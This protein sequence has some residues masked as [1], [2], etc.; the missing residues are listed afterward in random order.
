ME[1][2][3][4]VEP[5]SIDDLKKWV[6]EIAD[7][8]NRYQLKEI[9]KISGHS[10]PVSEDEDSLK[11]DEG[12]S[13]RK[14]MIGWNTGSE[15][16]KPVE[17]LNAAVQLKSPVKRL[18]KLEKLFDQTIE[19][20]PLP[21]SENYRFVQTSGQSVDLL[22]NILVDENLIFTTVPHGSILCAQADALVDMNR[23]EEALEKR[24]DAG[25]YQIPNT[26]QSA[27][28]AAMLLDL[29]RPEEAFAYFKDKIRFALKP[30]ELI[31][32]WKM[33]LHIAHELDSEDLSQKSEQYLNQ[34][35]GNKTINSDKT[36][37]VLCDL[38]N[39]GKAWDL[40]CAFDYQSYL[41]LE[42]LS[43]NVNSQIDSLELPENG[44]VEENLQKMPMLLSGMEILE[45]EKTIFQNPYLGSALQVLRKTY[46]G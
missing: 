29:G 44:S 8:N 7:R 28:V 31:L 42:L 12:D 33:M 2:L 24:L 5:D 30:D 21:E 9:M 1:V 15:R 35:L 36:E 39:S 46:T 22:Q 16:K 19:A 23:V 41:V 14:L 3:Q 43:S 13:F 40:N 17:A 10:L 45:L 20:F 26:D 27:I 11:S 4:T 34:I 32:Y 38:I 6:V 18:K 37:Q 25:R